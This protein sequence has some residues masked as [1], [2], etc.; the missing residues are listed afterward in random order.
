[1][2]TDDLPWGL[3]LCRKFFRKSYNRKKVV[4]AYIDGGKIILESNSKK[5][6]PEALKLGSRLGSIHAEMHVLFSVPDASKGT[7]YIYRETSDG[8]LGLARPCESCMKLL[9]QKGVKRIVYSTKNGFAKEK[10]LYQPLDK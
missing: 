2:E 4:A 3:Q 9:L 1:M 10:L 7:M 5:S 6:H 8:V